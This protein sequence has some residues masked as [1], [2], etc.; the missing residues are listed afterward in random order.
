MVI[1]IFNDTKI[2]EYTRVKYI[3]YY[4]KIFGIAPINLKI[5]TKNKVS[6]TY[7]VTQSTSDYFYSV[8][9]IF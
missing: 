6:W 1:K 5:E 2:E 8:F 4:F 9:L 3:F 7:I